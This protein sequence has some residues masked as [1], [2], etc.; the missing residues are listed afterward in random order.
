MAFRAWNG[1]ERPRT[2]L[3]TERSGSGDRF[4]GVFRLMNLVSLIV[5][6][7]RKG[8]LNVERAQIWRSSL[9]AAGYDVEM[10]VA[11]V[12]GPIATDVD[13]AASRVWRTI[14]DACGGTT[15][16]AI[17]GLR[18]ARGPILV[19]LDPTMG[20][21]PDDLVNV[22]EPLA[23]DAADLTIA[24]RFIKAYDSTTAHLSKSVKP[25]TNSSIIGRFVRKLL[26]TSDPF[27]GLVGVRRAALD[28]ADDD[29]SPAGSKFSFE[30]LSKIEGRVVEVP[31]R[32]ASR[33]HRGLSA[34]NPIPSIDDIRHLKR[35]AD[36]RFGEVSRLIQFCCVGFSGMFVDL[37]SYASFLFLFRSIPGL[38]AIKTPVFGCS[39]AMSLAAVAAITLALSWN[40]SLN[41]RLTFSYAREGSL[42]RQFI[43][44][45]LSNA[46]GAGLS[47]TIRLSLP[48]YF[49]F[50][51]RHNLAAAVV[52]IVLATGI[53]FSLARWVVF[54]NREEPKPKQN[55]DNQ[56]LADP[57]DEPDEAFAATTSLAGE[58]TV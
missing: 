53:N 4:S 19:I 12:G 22:V 17:A 31:G 20:Y 37:T 36:H 7:P 3:G 29:F 42:A 34:W 23:V 35:L 40:F 24:D 47:L 54:H 13:Q 39:L 1:F 46:L 27:T 18:S 33:I 30:L 21:A 51:F 57:S 26:G 38:D 56:T 28:A 55:T 15:E 32:P 14:G 49:G 58:S 10:I 41:R 16:A 50:F 9:E 43:T 25:K 11:R 2:L 5:P 45:A 44:Y 6:V 52:G 48:R 8:T